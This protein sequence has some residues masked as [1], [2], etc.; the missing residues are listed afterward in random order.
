MSTRGS[1]AKPDDL[2]WTG[3]YNHSDSYPT[4]LGRKLWH[5]YHEQYA[6]DLA[7]MIRVEIDEYRDPDDPTWRIVETCRCAIPGH[8]EGDG[9]DTGCTPLFIE[10]AYVL[11]PQ[12]M[13]V[14]HH[15]EDTGRTYTEHYAHGDY[16][17]PAYKHVRW[18]LVP[19]AGPEPDWDTIETD[20]ERT[21]KGA[22]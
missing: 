2:G 3:R 16:T 18:G 1:I 19:W 12:G 22:L 11:F 21:Q 20:V 9:Y 7:A 5:Q 10:W 14:W 8:T 13:E 4:W 6:G 15:I 17:R